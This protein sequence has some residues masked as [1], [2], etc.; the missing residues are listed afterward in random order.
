MPRAP[1][2]KNDDGNTA[3]LPEIMMIMMVA[4][5]HFHVQALD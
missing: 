2:A 3:E 5:R 1:E 4:S